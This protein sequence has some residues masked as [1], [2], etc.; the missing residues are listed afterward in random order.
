MSN[1]ATRKPGIFTNLTS[2]EL[3]DVMS[4]KYSTLMNKFLDLLEDNPSLERLSIKCH[5]PSKSFI[6]ALPRLS[7]LF[8]DRT[9]F[10]LIITHLETPPSTHIHITRTSEQLISIGSQINLFNALPEDLSHIGTF[11]DTQSL[12]FELGHGEEC[13]RFVNTTG[14]TVIV[15]EDVLYASRGCPCP[16]IFSKPSR[17]SPTPAQFVLFGLGI[18]HWG[19]FPGRRPPQIFRRRSGAGFSGICRDWAPFCWNISM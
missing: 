14:H 6:V 8:L 4:F 18:C 15:K 2:L 19:T 17:R 10:Y 3:L 1:V 12:T 5:G 13:L 16:L 7:S 11:H 9:C